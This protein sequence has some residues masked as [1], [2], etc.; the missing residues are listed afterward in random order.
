MFC[1]GSRQRRQHSVS[2][3]ANEEAGRWG[4][5]VP[6]LADCLLHI[7]PGAEKVG[8]LEA[9]ASAEHTF[10]TAQP[11]RTM[12]LTELTAS[13]RNRQVGPGE[14]EP[15]RYENRRLDED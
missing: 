12:G 7:G 1:C 9:T 10:G 13:L 15:L 11:S 14:S 3:A 5:I 4:S 6:I 8:G 2:N